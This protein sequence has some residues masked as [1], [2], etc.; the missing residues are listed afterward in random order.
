MFS[1][2]VYIYLLKSLNSLNLLIKKEKLKKIF[3]IHTTKTLILT[4]IKKLCQ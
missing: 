3:K 2:N 1:L 4:I